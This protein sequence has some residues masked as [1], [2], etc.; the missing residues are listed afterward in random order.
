MFLTILIFFS[1][2]FNLQEGEDI[3]QDFLQKVKKLP[4]DSLSS[5]ELEVKVNE[6]KAEVK[7]KENPY[8]KDLLARKSTTKS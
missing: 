1:V 8:I 6:L 4:L 7:A 3:I 5:E 2:L